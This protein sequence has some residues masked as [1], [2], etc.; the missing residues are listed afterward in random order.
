MV[1]TEPEKPPAAP[2]APPTSLVSNVGE[3]V[4]YALAV[5]SLWWVWPPLVLLAAGLVLIFWANVRTPGTGR[6][7]AAVGAALAAGRM[8][9]RAVHKTDETTTATGRPAT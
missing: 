7:G 1:T 8:A 2:A 9:W 5:A 4:G 6:T 3:F